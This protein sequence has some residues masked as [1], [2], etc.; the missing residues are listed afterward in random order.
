MNRKITLGITNPVASNY[1]VLIV[2][3]NNT[4]LSI[5]DNPNSGY[6]YFTLPEEIIGMDLLKAIEYSSSYDSVWWQIEKIDRISVLTWT[7]DK[8]KDLLYNQTIQLN[9]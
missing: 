3:S 6:H 4:V 1:A 5:I 2:D 9:K 8:I 7:Q